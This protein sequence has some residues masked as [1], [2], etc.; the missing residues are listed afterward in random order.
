MTHVLV[1]TATLKL[2]A[3]E[4]VEAV[5]MVQRAYYGGMLLHPWL[6]IVALQAVNAP[7]KS[8]AY[9]VATEH[10]FGLPGCEFPMI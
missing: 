5:Q 4:E 2:K 9:R 1:G 7:Q 8:L 10:L 6:S 3:V